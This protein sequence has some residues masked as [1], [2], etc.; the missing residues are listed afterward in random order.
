MAAFKGFCQQ[1]VKS[2]SIFNAACC[3]YMTLQNYEKTLSWNWFRNS[4]SPSLI[5][6]EIHNLK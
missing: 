3:L 1:N 5:H 4:P 2:K 6:R